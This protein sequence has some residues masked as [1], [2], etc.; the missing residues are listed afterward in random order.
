MDTI[1]Y[2]Y[3][4]R[5][6][7]EFVTE[8]WQEK[9]YCLIRLGVPVLL[10]QNLKALEGM[11]EGEKAK[12]SVSQE[13][14]IDPKKEKEQRR[15]KRRGFRKRK[16]KSEEDSVV[17]DP[18]RKAREEEQERL[19]DLRNQ[20]TP[21]LTELS[22]LQTVLSLLGDNPHWIYCVYEDYLYERIDTGLWWDV[23]RLPLFE[24]Y[25][26][27]IRVEE[28][29]QYA[30]K[31]SFVVLGC[32][33]CVGRILRGHA[34]RMRSVQWIMKPEQYTE[35]VQEFV[36]EFYEEYGLAITMKLLEEGEDW[37][38]VRP[39]SV[40]PVN[41]LDFSGEEK[42]SVCDIAKGSVWLDMDSLEGKERRMEV[43]SPQIG[44]FSLKKQWKQLQKEPIYLDTIG[45]NRY[46]T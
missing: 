8:K 15:K 34:A 17:M 6:K 44:Y 43:R 35:A 37:I 2:L 41:V 29:M 3:H 12:R 28:L 31:E 27:Y 20:L 46:N 33:P 38:R 4:S 32:A 5:E 11:A 22:E 23:W 36:E 39:S 14:V 16:Q 30:T 24:E 26:S 40:Q 42:L 18:E 10:W 9:E 25:H 1:I 21:L 19:K 45:Q 13:A 7:E